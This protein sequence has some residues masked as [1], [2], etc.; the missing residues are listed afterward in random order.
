MINVEKYCTAGQT[1]KHSKK[2][3]MFVACWVLKDTNTLLE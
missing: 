2:R 1:T 3:V